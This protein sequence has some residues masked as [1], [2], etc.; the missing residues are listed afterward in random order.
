M[1]VV[2]KEIKSVC[3]CVYKR[4]GDAGKVGKSVSMM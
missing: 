4:E 1:E 2:D 3:V